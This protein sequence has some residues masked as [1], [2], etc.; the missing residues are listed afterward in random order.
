MSEPTRQPE[1]TYAVFCL[2]KKKKQCRAP[3]EFYA[4]K[5]KE[6][7]SPSRNQTLALTNIHGPT[8]KAEKQ[9][10]LLA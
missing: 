5:K 3:K 2:I 10:E 4:K 1:S 8:R 9:E 7:N 6:S